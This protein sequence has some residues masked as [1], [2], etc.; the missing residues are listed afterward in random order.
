MVSWSLISRKVKEPGAVA[1]DQVDSIL[2][3]WEAVG[4]SVT[5][6]SVRPVL[7]LSVSHAHKDTDNTDLTVPN[8]VLRRTIQPNPSRCTSTQWPFTQKGPVRLWLHQLDLLRV[9]T[10]RRLSLSSLRV[11]MSSSHPENT[12]MN[13][14]VSPGCGGWRGSLFTKEHPYQPWRCYIRTCPR[15]G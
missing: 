11:Y 1:N 5:R 4:C 9:K 13:Q 2:L 6:L 12:Q 14:P 8:S 15:C 7:A 3:Y 10:N